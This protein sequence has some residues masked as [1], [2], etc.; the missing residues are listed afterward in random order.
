[1]NINIKYLD[2]T[3]HLSSSYV[4]SLEIENKKL[5]FRIVN[6]F[7]NIANGNITDEIYISEE[8]EEIDISNKVNIVIDYFN[9][10][11]NT[12]KNLNELT[13]NLKD[14][15]G[16]KELIEITTYYNKIEKIIV[17]KATE[18]T[19]KLNIPNEFNIDNLLKNF[20]FE[21][22]EKTN[23]INKLYLLLD[24]EMLL[25]YN[26]LIIFVNIKQYLEKKDI[27]ELIKYAQY[28][29]LNLLLIDNNSYGITMNNEKKLI[30]DNDLVEFQ[31]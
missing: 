31:L 6:D 23:L 17:G 12:R 15:L 5:F 22:E 14:N 2:N 8:N 7:C 10:D 20:K 29:E 27:E 19:V 1:M 18:T 21:I 24:L 13:K 28:N 9:L 11:F 16:E 4:T 30:V 3:L 26:K 25:N